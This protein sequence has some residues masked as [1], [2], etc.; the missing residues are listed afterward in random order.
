MVKDE[1]DREA[2]RTEGICPSLSWWSGVET[3]QATGIH[4][5]QPSAFILLLYPFTHGAFGSCQDIIAEIWE[6]LH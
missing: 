5:L 3:V 1:G 2:Q 4:N 6:T